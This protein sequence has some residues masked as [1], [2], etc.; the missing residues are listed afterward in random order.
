MH[1]LSTFGVKTNHGQSQT[2]KTHHNSEF[3]ETTTFPLIV[4]SVP[5]H[6]G[7]IQMAFCSKIPEIPKVGTPATLGSHNFVWKIPIAIRSQ[8]KL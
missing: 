3:G 1:S 5:L 7:H 6:G 4:F 8:K 2:H